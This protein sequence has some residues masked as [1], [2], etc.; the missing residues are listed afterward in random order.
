ME[1]IPLLT[2]NPIL[3]HLYVICN[4]FQNRDLLEMQPDLTLHS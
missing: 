4:L 1:G 2:F 3:E